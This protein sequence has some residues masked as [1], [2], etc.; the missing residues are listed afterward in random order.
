MR[1]SF[2]RLFCAIYP[3]VSNSFLHSLPVLWLCA[4]PQY[5]H[6]VVLAALSENTA[7]FLANTDQ[8][9]LDFF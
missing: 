9:G 5:K 6:S 3:N 2:T 1:S 8:E 4:F 7:Y